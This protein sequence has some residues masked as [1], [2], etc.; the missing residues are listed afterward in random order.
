MLIHMAKT[1]AL[2]KRNK[3]K[4]Q[5]SYQHFWEVLRG[6]QKVTESEINF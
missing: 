4:I 6:K 2:K 5:K 3:H 1:W